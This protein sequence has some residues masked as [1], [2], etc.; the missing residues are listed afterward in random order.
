MSFQTNHEHVMQVFK[1][2]PSLKSCTSKAYKQ[3]QHTWLFDIWNYV[4]YT[5][6]KLHIHCMYSWKATLKPILAV[7]ECNNKQCF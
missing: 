7:E 3:L 4:N 1:D 2:K 5:K 6:L